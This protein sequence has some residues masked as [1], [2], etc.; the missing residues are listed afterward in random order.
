MKK[1]ILFFS[2]F[3]CFL[4][5][6]GQTTSVLNF[7]HN[8]AYFTPSN[9]FDQSTRIDLQSVSY[10]SNLSVGLKTQL[11]SVQKRLNNSIGL[12]GLINRTTIGKANSITGFDLYLNYS[13]K[14]KESSS[15]TA[16]AGLSFKS[17]DYN[18]QLLLTSFDENSGLFTYGE[19]YFRTNSTGVPL[20]LEFTNANFQSG[21]YFDLGINQ[22]SEYGVYGRWLSF[23]SEKDVNIFNWI[24]GALYDK[25]H[26]LEL[27]ISNK[28]SVENAGI[29]LFANSNLAQGYTSNKMSFGA[30]IFY[31]WKV[32]NINYSFST[33]KSDLGLNHQLGMSIFLNK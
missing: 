2:V 19:E 20:G 28:F 7:F 32:F 18:E 23:A 16:G 1:N 25:G 4:S 14:V 22:K 13:L 33:N 9:K 6:S 8:V 15:L 24:E 12:G 26:G 10:F 11:F 31:L 27:M 3:L 21:I 17:T 30:S 29:S 5:L